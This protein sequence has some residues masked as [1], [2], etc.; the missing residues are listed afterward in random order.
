M[1]LQIIVSENRACHAT[2]ENKLVNASILDW[3][4]KQVLSFKP[5]T[6]SGKNLLDFIYR[7]TFSWK[8][9]PLESAQVVSVGK[10][11]KVFKQSTMSSRGFL[12]RTHDDDSFDQPEIRQLSPSIVISRSDFFTGDSG[13]E[14]TDC[15]WNIVGLIAFYR[16][17]RQRAKQFRDNLFVFRF[18][19]RSLKI[20]N[21]FINKHES[22]ATWTSVCVYVCAIVF[23]VDNALES[24]D[25]QHAHIL[26]C[27]VSDDIFRAT[28]LLLAREF[29]RR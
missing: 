12:L 25:L 24:E 3:T 17:W 29:L 5:I 27:H 16:L 9:K 2:R 8:K 14:T 7:K 28:S 13:G 19:L 15:Q 1:C 22:A 6:W 10:P 4:Y 18:L 23:L 11:G 21:R 26:M 20:V